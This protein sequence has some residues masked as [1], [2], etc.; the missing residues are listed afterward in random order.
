ME[1]LDVLVCLSEASTEDDTTFLHVYWV[2]WGVDFYSAHRDE[3]LDL[4]ISFLVLGLIQA[5]ELAELVR[6][7][8]NHPVGQLLPELL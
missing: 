4:F 2:T 5:F 3:L 1:Q 7:Q 8:N 6:V